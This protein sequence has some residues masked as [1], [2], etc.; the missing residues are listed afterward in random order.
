M[1]FCPSCGVKLT[2]ATQAFCGN[3]GDELSSGLV[4][5]KPAERE[6]EDEPFAPP[7]SPEYCDMMSSSHDVDRNWRA[8][9]GTTVISA[10][11]QWFGDPRVSSR[12]LFAQS[13]PDLGAA[14]EESGDWMADATLSRSFTLIPHGLPTGSAI[15]PR[16]DTQLPMTGSLQG[17]RIQ[18]LIASMGTVMNTWPGGEALVG[19]WPTPGGGR[20]V[21]IAQLMRNEHGREYLYWYSTPIFSLG[22]LP[23]NDVAHIS[24]TVAIPAALETMCFLSE[25]PMPMQSETLMLLGGRGPVL[26]GPRSTFD[27]YPVPVARL[28]AGED[29]TSTMF[30]ACTG[31]DDLTATYWA[32][33]RVDVGLAID[34]QLADSAVMR[35]I[36]VAIVSSQRIAV[37]L[38]DGFAHHQSGEV[39]FGSMMLSQSAVVDDGEQTW[40]PTSLAGSLEPLLIRAE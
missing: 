9:F 28:S 7:V 16:V 35:S 26:F 17:P 21:Q 1:N 18:K 12:E 2:R 39:A 31:A 6:A 27:E 25:C 13:A 40:L 33:A 8:V 5:G 36:Q 14:L 23:N 3:C 20:V 11:N 10:A 29:D 22:A 15:N 30:M 38:E 32:G 24:A 34:L 19:W 37:I 4:Q